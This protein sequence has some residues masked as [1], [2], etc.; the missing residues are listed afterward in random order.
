MAKNPPA[1]V[2][3]HHSTK[4][5]L[6]TVDVAELSPADRVAREIVSVRKDLSPSV[7]RIMDAELEDAAR[8]R[9]IELFRDALQTTGDPNR[10]PRV[11]I[12]AVQE[13][14]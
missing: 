13:A 10:D 7:A 14:G 2:G 3:A 5:Y 4:P 8:L 1:R 9:A 6:S 11:A 12:A